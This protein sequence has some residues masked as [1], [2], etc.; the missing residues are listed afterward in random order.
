MIRHHPSGE[1]L[2]GYAAGSISPGQALVVGLHIDACAQCRNEVALLNGLGGSLLAQAAP[3]ALSEGALER[4]LGRLD[5]EPAPARTQNALPDFLA[6][7]DIP[8]R[9]QDSDIGKR[10]WLAPGIWF[11]PIEA[12]PR[13]EQR[14]YLIYGDKGRLLPQHTHP[15]QELTVVLKGAY[16]DDL[17]HFARGDFA[18]A[19]E[20]I[21]HAQRVTDDGECLCLI[22]SAGPMMPAGLIARLVQSYAARRY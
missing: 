21:S 13:G 16:T 12:E 18:E 2:A 19:D 8:K 9:L 3:M 22:T 7:F 5:K 14:T 10:R 20:T 17:G 11:A 1:I 4:M 6:R 15:G